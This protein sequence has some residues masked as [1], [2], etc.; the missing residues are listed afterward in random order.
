MKTVAVVDNYDSF[1]WNLVQHLGELG[2]RTKVVKNDG[3]DVAAIRTLGAVGLL[4]SPGP[5]TPER[6]GVT[7]EAA[8]ALAGELPILGVCLGH[9][10][11]A[12]AFGGSIVPALR[13]VHG[14]TSPIEHDGETIFSGLPSPFDATR[15][16]SWVVTEAKLPT[17]LAVSARTAEGEIM[18]LRHRSLPV[19]GVQFH[20][21]SVLTTWGKKLLANWIARLR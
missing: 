7:L 1:T 11:I 18:A 16:H 15:Y 6:A 4:L 17:C 12:Q 9:Q 21:E 10:A 20:P 13:L 8:R 5:S 3:V 19:E 14:E 2:V